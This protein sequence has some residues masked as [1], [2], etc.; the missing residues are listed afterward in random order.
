MR[1]DDETELRHSIGRTG[2]RD[3]SLY[4][5]VCSRSSAS[6]SRSSRIRR[7]TQSSLRPQNLPTSFIEYPAASD[8]PI[9][10]TIAN[11][12][13]LSASHGIPSV[14]AICAARAF[15]AVPPVERADVV[16]KTPA[17]PLVE[18]R[19]EE[20]ACTRRRI[21]PV[22]VDDLAEQPCERVFEVGLL[23]AGLPG[24]FSDDTAAQRL[25][26]VDVAELPHPGQHAPI[27]VHQRAAW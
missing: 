8:Q 14:I 25:D 10:S 9:V 19:A 27:V 15:L 26:V 17:E 16:D 23:E 5:A 18:P 20:D 13:G 11:A 3:P 6:S 2:L 21:L 24:E 4:A 22:E 12:R 1:L 7:E